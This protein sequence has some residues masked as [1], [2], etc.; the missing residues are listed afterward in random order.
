MNRPSARLL[1]DAKAQGILFSDDNKTLLWC[2][3]D[4]VGAVVIPPCVTRIGKAAF[5]R[6][7]ALTGVM[8]PDSVTE[9]GY[10]AFDG[11]DHLRRV[12]IPGSVE[13]IGRGA[14][15]ACPLTEVSIPERAEVGKK[16]FPDTCRVIRRAYA[17]VPLTAADI[18]PEKS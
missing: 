6:C 15:L 10:S 7:T 18:S 3:L 14:F 11:C 5:E 2:P 12:T 8:I 1:Q 16:V 4:V 17:P 9:I 13:R